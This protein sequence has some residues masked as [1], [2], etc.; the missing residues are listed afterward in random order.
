MLT[1]PLFSGSA[2]MIVSWRGSPKVMIIIWRPSGDHL[3][4][5]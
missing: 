2:S 1:M 5:P 3:G 4:M